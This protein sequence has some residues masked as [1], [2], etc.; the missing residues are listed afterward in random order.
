M[1][2]TAAIMAGFL[3][4]CVGSLLV[5]CAGQGSPP[6][7]VAGA[8]TVTF[9]LVTY[10]PEFSHKIA[11]QLADAPPELSQVVIDYEK[12]RCA[13]NPKLPVCADLLK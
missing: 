7:V 13:I 10:S 9:P 11:S 12:L 5:A 2:S 8:V 1:K 6:P 4:L 3:A